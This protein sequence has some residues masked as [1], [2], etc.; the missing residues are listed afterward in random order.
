MPE[1]CS[2]CGVDFVG[3]DTFLK[4]VEC[5]LCFHPTC[6]KNSSKTRNKQW[7][8]D[9]CKGETSSVKSNEDDDTQKLLKAMQEMKC[10]ITKQVGGVQESIDALR[11]DFISIQ[12]RITTVET[13]QQDLGARCSQLEQERDRLSAEVQ[14]LRQLQRDADQ[15]SRSANLEIQGLPKTSEE[16]IYVIL[17]K[18]AQ[19]LN[20]PFSKE[21]VSIAHR[22]KQYSK[23]HRH[24]PII[25]QFVSREKK[26]MWLVAARRKKGLR[27]SEIAASLPTSDVYI[28]E[29]LTPYN[30]MMLGRARGLVRAKKLHF[31]G[32][33][34]GKVLIKTRDGEEA[35]RVTRLEDLDKYD[36]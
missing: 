30:K 14:E 4:C 22:L 6:T 2:V 17:A 32:Y 19:A 5:K 20:V 25:A 28:N 33:Y 11:V 7:K 12:A 26:E 24:P 9:S 10:D 13:S 36:Q 35:V 21:D 3:G 27:A 15:H 16:S 31:A 23:K 8:C 34:N 29:H 1:K 18:L